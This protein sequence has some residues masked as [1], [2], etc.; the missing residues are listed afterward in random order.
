MFRR[1]PVAGEEAMRRLVAVA[2]E[3]S[4]GARNKGGLGMGEGEGNTDPRCRG[5]ESTGRWCTSSQRMPL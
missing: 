2:E 4:P 5:R 1:V 3:G